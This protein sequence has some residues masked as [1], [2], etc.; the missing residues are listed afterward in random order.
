M[1]TLSYENLLLVIVLP[2]FDLE[3]LLREDNHFR[4]GT[5]MNNDGS[6]HDAH[7][8]TPKLTR[9]V[10]E[11]LGKHNWSTNFKIFP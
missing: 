9:R 8:G 5:S 10:K 11:W 4:D 1:K 2:P 6:P 7:R 3:K